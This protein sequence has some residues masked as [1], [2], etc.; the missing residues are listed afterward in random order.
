M[1]LAIAESRDKQA[2]AALFSHF[3]PRLK[4]WLTSGGADEATAE[5][6]AQETML[7]VWRRAGSYRPDRASPS[8]WI[9]TIARNKRIDRLRRQRRPTVALDA[10][11]VERKPS[12]VRTYSWDIIAGEEKRLVEALAQLP[13]EQSELLRQVYVEDKSHRHIAAETGIALG[14]V[15]S[16]IRLAMQRLRDEYV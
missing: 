12:G 4:S 8:T 16:R 11:G 13:A 5:E 9:F 3:A 6:L 7:T 14:T 15:K 2:F 1:L 10:P